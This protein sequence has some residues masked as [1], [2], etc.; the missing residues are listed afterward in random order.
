MVLTV[1]FAL[2]LVTGLYCHHRS[3]PQRKLGI[4][5]G[6][7]GPH[8]FAVRAQHRSPSMLPR[9]SHPA[10]NVRDDG[11]TPLFSG[12]GQREM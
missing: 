6:M 2:S 8:D 3:S 5:V 10:P 11:D 12:T 1:S 4:S 9:P 7:P